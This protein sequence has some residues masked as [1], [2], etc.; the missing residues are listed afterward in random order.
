ML[1]IF[2]NGFHPEVSQTNKKVNQ[3][4]TYSNWIH[5]K[6]FKYLSSLIGKVTLAIFIIPCFIPS[7]R[8]WVQASYIKLTT[9]DKSPPL[10]N[11][12]QSIEHWQKKF[13]SYKHDPNLNINGDLRIAQTKQDKR[14]YKDNLKKLDGGHIARKYPLMGRV[15]QIPGEFG[16]WMGGVGLIASYL[17]AKH[18]LEGLYVCNTL[19][20]FTNK[21]HEFS[22]NISG[23][24]AAFIIPTF[25]PGQSGKGY[26]PDFPQHKITVVAEKK[27]D[28][29]KIAILDSEASGKNIINPSNLEC[30]DVWDNWGKND[31][32]NRDELALR[33][34]LKV[35]LLQ[36][37]EIFYSKVSRE[38]TYGCSVYALKDAVA[39]LEDPSFF[40]KIKTEKEEVKINNGLV[41]KGIVKLPAALMVGAQSYTALENYIKE[42][43]IEELKIT[44]KNKTLQD[45]MTKYSVKVAGK[46]Q[47]HY[48][49][50]KVYKYTKIVLN[51]LNTLPNE[52][53]DEILR[54]T[55]IT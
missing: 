24:R 55:F 12:I 44:S 17:S 16:L 49:T 3:E 38:K 22:Q 32:F 20:A 36:N 25:Y 46:N 7:Y 21:L 23:E 31:A 40:D 5:S 47:N 27:A 30:I 9:A 52:N 34:I 33:A 50:K 29:I 11:K 48:I 15:N 18:K 8:K 19:D 45:Y 54:K 41:I 35:P 13:G 43:A 1:K 28:Q 39:Y 26:K 2:R 14:A 6:K 53:V 10:P 51:I 4:K 42:T 37:S